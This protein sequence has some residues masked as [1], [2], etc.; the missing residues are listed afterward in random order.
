MPE[1]LDIEQARHMLTQVL[2]G[3]EPHL[4]FAHGRLIV[5]L[6]DP[7]CGI[8]GKTLVRIDGDPPLTPDEDK[9]V[10]L[11]MEAF[12]QIMG[13]SPAMYIPGDA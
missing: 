7:D 9:R 11:A 10:G 3:L 1:D 13:G 6:I 4:G 5:T 12:S 8:P 2:R